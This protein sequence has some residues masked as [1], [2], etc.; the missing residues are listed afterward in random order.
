M[1]NQI[2]G[3]V[4]HTSLNWF[5]CIQFQNAHPDSRFTETVV[6]VGK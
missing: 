3:A 5:S 4:C 1:F 6:D 2:S